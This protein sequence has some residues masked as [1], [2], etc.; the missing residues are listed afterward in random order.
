MSE[1]R[2]NIRS[3]MNW[4]F[5]QTQRRCEGFPASLYVPSDMPASR[6]MS[7]SPKRE[8]AKV[9]EAMTEAVGDEAEMPVTTGQKPREGENLKL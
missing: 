4:R 5:S 9:R 1:K 8:G 7:V 3:I 6:A 2:Y